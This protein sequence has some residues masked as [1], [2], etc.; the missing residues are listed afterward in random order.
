[1]SFRNIILPFVLVVF[2]LGNMAYSQIVNYN[3]KDGLAFN[4]VDH[5]S[6]DDEG[7]I[8]ISTGEGLNVFDGSQFTLFNLHN[9]D[10]FSNKI[11]QT[12][13]LKKGLILIGTQDMGLFILDKLKNKIVPLVVKKI[14]FESL[15]G[16]NS[17]FLDS[18]NIVWVGSE[19]GTL[20]S[21]PLT[22][23]DSNTS[24]Y[25]LTDA[26]VLTTLSGAI[27]TILEVGNTMLIGIEDSKIFR[28][29]KSNHNYIIDDPIEVEGASRITSLAIDKDALFLGTNKGLYKVA[30]FVLK[31]NK[32]AYS[33]T[34]TWKLDQTEIR[35]LTPYKNT[36]W[37]GTEGQGIYN[38]SINGKE[39]EHFQY[40][41]NKRNNLNS[42]YVLTT[43]IDSNNN[44]WIGTWFGGMNVIDLSEKNYSVIYDEE[45]E[46][47]LFSNIIWA[48]A[49][50]PDGRVFIG[51]HG[52]GLG[53]H[54]TGQKNFKS[55]VNNEDIRSISTLYYDP[56]SKLLLIGTWGNGVKMYDP[57]TQKLVPNIY[58]LSLL[59]QDRISSITR[60]PV[61]NLWIGSL[62]N[63]L[64]QLQK[65]KAQLE[66]INLPNDS[67]ATPTDIKSLKSDIKN[68]LLWAG[69]SKNGLFSLELDENGNIGNI[70]NY[71]TFADNSD[72]I[73]VENLF[74]HNNGDLWV[75]CRNGIGIVKPNEAPER[76]PLIDGCVVTG[77]AEDTSNNLWVGTRKGIFKLDPEVVTATYT[78]SQYSCFN[79]LYNP[80]DNT[81]LTGTDDGLLRI[82]PDEPLRLPPFPTL[83]LSKLNVLSQTITPQKEFNGRVILPQNLNYLDTIILPHN[84]QSFSI[85]LNA[86]TYTGKKKVRLQHRLNKFEQE[87]TEST[88]ISNI[89]NYTNVPS[90]TYELEV[91]VGHEHLGWN[92]QSRK[93]TII[94]LKPWWASPLAYLVYAILLI[95]ILYIIIKEVK[96]RI[97]INQALKIEKIKQEGIHE[98]YQQKLSIF[99]NV[100]H[101][102]RT[103]LTLIIGPIEEMLSSGEIEQKFQRKLLRMHKN[104]QMLL[105]LVNQILNFRQAEN[106][107]M[108]LELEQIDLNAFVENTCSQFQELAQTNKIDFE[109]CCPEEKL[110]LVADSNKLESIL[111]NLIS[112]AIKFTPKYGEVSVQVYNDENYISISVLDTG[113]GIPKDDL[114]SIFS[115]FYRSRNCEDL[116]GNGIGTTLVKKYTEI[117]NGKI[118]VHSVENEGTEFIVHFPIIDEFSKY[119]HHIIQTNPEF[120]TEN[121]PKIETSPIN[122]KDYSVLVIDDSEDIREYLK[123]ILEDEYK[124]YTADNGKEG[125]SITHNKMPDLV[126]SDIMMKGITGTEVCSQIK[127]NVNTSHIP[128]IQ[129]TAKT[130]MDSKIEG[131]EKGADA[132]IEKP[133][134]SKLLLTRVKKIIEKKENIRKTMLESD[135][136]LVE[137]QPQSVDERFIEKIISLIESNISDSEFSVQS[138]IENMDMSQ[139]Q[140]YRKIK[141]LT[142][143]SI[144]HFIRLVRLK[145]AAR[146][147][148]SGD[149]TVSEVLF[150]VGFNN[151][152]YFTR[153]FKAE[154]GVLPKDYCP[155]TA[156]TMAN[157]DSN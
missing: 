98:L 80:L 125:L 123:E 50:L 39:L 105:N 63:G 146:L 127:S 49:I 108:D 61:G 106:N 18:N 42:D 143:L 60:G 133:F 150:K 115:Q 134:N 82:K 71:T 75:L 2:F 58:N 33:L 77:I 72:K 107:M 128:V 104:G 136:L 120:S 84:S 130:S 73:Y 34:D 114:E 121:S 57:E 95:L 100:S 85:D 153:C 132:Y 48:T 151:P 129:L 81:I 96:A 99:T 140:L 109:V 54:I 20:F 79:V 113:I 6:E 112:N 131:F 29:R 102:L 22:D 1:M 19:N 126:I 21:F 152:S 10:G 43:F 78:L 118:E 7:L 124:V 4:N 62:E 46:K 47:N 28:I 30:D 116:Q 97:R 88:G 87:W 122:P 56:I 41:Q 68:N 89:A 11:S 155:T 25:E 149:Y 83:M 144:N 59:N 51:T 154:F 8:Y 14:D 66:K 24:D 76:H 156:P 157:K 94:K 12:L 55:I 23:I 64:F 16:I 65:D 36:I 111:I 90:G 147:L 148:A 32:N 37:V 3:T 27:H 135:T 45:N 137:A 86:L 5:I 91:R 53:E 138:L 92:P 119:P 70:K 145:K 17:L 142:G 93:L 13:F 110:T 103:P 15:L 35:S 38:L 40:E 31:E 52:N 141:A 139:D 101:D 9:T 67:S 117:H 26:E 69:S 44:L 74:L